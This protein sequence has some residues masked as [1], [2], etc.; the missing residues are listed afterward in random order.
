L[1][2]RNKKPFRHA[3]KQKIEVA[4]RERQTRNKVE[5]GIRNCLNPCLSLGNDE[6]V[7]FGQEGVRRPIVERRDYQVEVRKRFI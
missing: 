6:D 1:R 2:K 5:N 4:G 3:W 7:F